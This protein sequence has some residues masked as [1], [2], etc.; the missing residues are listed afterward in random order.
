MFFE[1]LWRELR[2]RSR[3]LI[4]ISLGL[5]V[6]IGLVITVTAASA[7]VKDAQ[8]TV[9]HALYGV[10]TDITVTQSPAAGSNNPYQFYFGGGHAAPP[11]AGSTI[12]RTVLTSPGLGPLK[13]SSVTA[14][15]RLRYVSAAAGAL[16]L[17]ET[18]ISGTIPS[19]SRPS[20]G[21]GS[22]SV[23]SLSVDGVQLSAAQ[24]GVLS[25]ATLTSG[26]TF[27]MADANSHVAVVES[28]YATQNTLKA[29]SAVSVDGTSFTVIGIVTMPQGS[30]TVDVFIPLAPAQALSGMKDEVNTIYVAASSDAVIGSVAAEI[31]RILP[32]A[33]VTTSSTLASE[34]TGSLASASSL[35]SNLGKWLAIAV[36]AAAFLLAAVLMVAAVSRRVR[37]FGTL[38]ALGWRT[39]RIIRQ[40]MGE[41]L[42]MCLLGGVAGVVL[43]FIGAWLIDEFAPSLTASTG[44]P[45]YGRAGYFGPASGFRRA[46]AAAG[47]TATIHLNAPVSGSAI[48]AAV[49]LAIA[50][51]LIAGSFASW[52][53]A[54][55]RPAAAL[56]QV[57]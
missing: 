20:G 50:G 25:S 13:A 30:A 1:Y 12:N 14:I 4:F 46:A 49:L 35:A 57:A 21:T 51:G 42:A 47:R 10:G 11:T 55:L 36:L 54:R 24:V 22:F 45:T 32:K 18:H 27:T 17:T 56:T 52:R 40:V 37:E 26:R 31:S 29:G 53:A 28:G 41:A 23:S 9:L 15:S 19:V 34:I 33:T 7:G 39:R 5:A 16:V 8:G 38:K 6:G 48:A 3:Q 44:L 2:R 43:G